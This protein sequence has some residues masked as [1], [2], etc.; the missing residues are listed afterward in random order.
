MDRHRD[1]T[2]IWGV[3]AGDGAGVIVGGIIG[4]GL[5]GLL[6]GTFFVLH[7]DVSDEDIG[8]GGLVMVSWNIVVVG[9]ILN[10]GCFGCGDFGF[11]TFGN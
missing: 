4:V 3:E 6:D 5:A 8:N 10:G 7:F 2:V 1:D 9:G 11:G